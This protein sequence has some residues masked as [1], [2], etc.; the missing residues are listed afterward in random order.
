MNE[1]EAIILPDSDES[2]TAETVQV[3]RSRNGRYYFAERD[4]RWDGATHVNCS[5]CGKPWPKG[6]TICSSCMNKRDWQ[7]WNNAPRKEWDG[8]VMLYSDVADQYFRGEEEV[9]DYCDDN[10]DDGVVT[11][12]SL[13]LYICE[14]NY[15]DTIDGSIWEDI[16]PEDNDIPDDMQEAVDALN[17][18][19]IS[20]RENGEAVSWSP[21][22]YVPSFV[23]VEVPV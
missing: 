3:W 10:S 11:P 5:E 4:A 20:R 7:K 21:G 13:R 1:T 23:D 19:I 2:A 17:K 12:K 14:P 8:V 16:V 22:K 18:V 6:R 9:T 15:A